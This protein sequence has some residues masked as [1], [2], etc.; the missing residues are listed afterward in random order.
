MGA[1]HFRQLDLLAAIYRKAIE[2]G[3]KPGAPRHMGI[4]YKDASNWLGREKLNPS[5]FLRW[6]HIYHRNLSLLKRQTDAKVHVHIQPNLKQMGD[7]LE[8][9][10]RNQT[11]EL[12]ESTDLY[13][14]L[15]QH[16]LSADELH[17]RRQHEQTERDK[18]RRD[19]EALEAPPIEVAPPRVEE[20]PPVELPVEEAPA[21][22]AVEAPPPSAIPFPVIPTEFNHQVTITFR[23][24]VS[25][26]FLKFAKTLTGTLGT[27]L[28]LA[29]EELQ[30]LGKGEEEPPPAAKK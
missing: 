25:P 14:W 24:E 11:S 22:P 18:R 21:P 16:F 27:L 29:A 5:T 26:D 30:Q 17:A 7:A 19:R 3:F 28:G 12:D 10:V 4:P 9:A 6:V 1:K 2:T 20:A 23:L 13:T 15:E 8:S